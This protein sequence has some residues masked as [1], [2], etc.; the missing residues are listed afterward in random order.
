MSD[1][2]SE[3]D[4]S[5]LPPTLQRP[6]RDTT[7]Q[8][9]TNDPLQVGSATASDPTAASSAST[10]SPSKSPR[11]S[12]TQRPILP[13]P[14]QHFKNSVHR[15]IAARRTPTMMLSSHVGAEP[16]IDPRRASANAHYG[17]LRQQC[18]IEL[19]DYSVSRCS[20]GRM[21]NQEL[22]SYLSDP[23]ASEKEPWTKVRWINVGG[24]SW[25]VIS[26]LALRY[27][28]HP[29][30]IEDMLHQHGH[31]RSKADYYPKH[32]FLRLLCH[33]LAPDDDISLDA[34]LGHMPVDPVTILRSESPEPMD[35]EHPDDKGYETADEDHTMYGSSPY[36]G[37]SSSKFSAK[38]KSSA[39]VDVEAMSG[40]KPRPRPVPHH[41]WSSSF[42]HRAH[43]KQKHAQDW[44]LIQKLKKGERVNVKLYP[45]CI[46]LFRDDPKL[47]FT[48]PIRDRLRQSDTGLRTT[49]DPSLLVQSLIDLIVDQALEVVEEYQ[50]KILNIEKAVLL[51]PNMKTVTSL[52]VFQEDLI[53]HKRTLEPLKT[54]V[55][56]LRRYDADRAAAIMESEDAEMDPAV[57]PVGYMSDK[58]KIYLADV[59]DH[60]EYILNSLEMF[61]GISDNLINYTCNMVSY[62]M[63]EVMRR[64]TLVTII[65]LP[66]S[67][68]SGYFG[69]NFQHMWSTMT[70][71]HSDLLYVA[72]RLFPTF[73]PSLIVFSIN[74]VAAYPIRGTI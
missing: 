43:K 66:L 26:A 52:H 74:Y 59:Y 49:A 35:P 29:L 70:P 31:A 41:S 11:P 10:F 9:A 4:C 18:V 30:A 55:Y 65:F 64:L 67:F 48:A 39:P 73:G 25:D 38:G 62:E 42:M 16:G 5:S 2:S 12:D 6:L 20:F 46:F 58:A 17:N 34:S 13:H 15:V 45:V 53:L 36:I 21:T 54:L 19:V 68:L 51:K 7:Y 60:L 69:M 8:P 3:S 56:G 47:D 50:G 71:T 24:M 14:K 22:V 61:A 23:V 1:S 27:D 37:A 63:N 72:L 32:L 57:R 33:R 40:E 28:M 44:K